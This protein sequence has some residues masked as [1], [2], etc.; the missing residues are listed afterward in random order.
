[1]LIILGIHQERAAHN[2]SLQIR[3]IADDGRSIGRGP[4]TA[5]Q[6][7]LFQE[8]IAEGVV[9]IG[10]GKDLHAGIFFAV[11][12]H[13]AEAA[14]G[15]DGQGNGV[16]EGGGVEICRDLAQRL[17]FYR[18][19]IIFVPIDEACLV[20]QNDDGGGH[21]NI[22]KR[23]GVFHFARNAHG[24]PFIVG[25]LSWRARQVGYIHRWLLNIC[26]RGGRGFNGGWRGGDHN[27]NFDLHDFG[28]GGHIAFVIIRGARGGGRVFAA[29]CQQQAQAEKQK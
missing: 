10:N 5:A 23:I 6:V 11:I 2:F 21:A 7:A 13:I 8:G 24:T 17:G 25:D 26:C 12:V 28:R 3:V 4:A 9:P 14:F 19:Q 18:H 20:F 16:V 15:L 29:G 22:E 27:G 1:M